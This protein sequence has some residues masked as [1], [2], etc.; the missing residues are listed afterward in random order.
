MRW[1]VFVLVA[2]GG[3]AKQPASPEQGGTAMMFGDWKGTDSPLRKQ[4]CAA[5]AQS[6]FAI[7]V[8][9]AAE[10]Y[11]AG[12]QG[13]HTIATSERRPIE[14]CGAM[15]ELRWLTA[16]RCDDGKNPWGGNMGRAHGF[17]RRAISYLSKEDA[18]TPVIDVYEADCPEGVYAVFMDMDFCAPGENWGEGLT[19]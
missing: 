19:H 14:V 5:K 17:R 3:D 7:T 13:L 2:C 16:A 15:N 10:R 9:Q 12:V 18:C 6:P 4:V 1:A 11:G 8:T